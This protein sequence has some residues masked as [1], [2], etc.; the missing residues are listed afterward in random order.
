[1]TRIHI[2]MLSFTH[3]LKESIYIHKKEIYKCI[4]NN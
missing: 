2:A 1:M 3:L 4:I